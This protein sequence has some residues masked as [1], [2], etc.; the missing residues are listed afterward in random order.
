MKNL[1][2]ILP[3]FEIENQYPDKIVVGIDEAGRGPIAGPVVAGLV[4][5]SEN[6]KNDE[7]V[8]SVND[9]KKISKKKRK[10]LFEYLTKEVKF[11]VGVVNNDK[12]DEINILNATK[13]AMFR[14]YED[15][16]AKYAINVDVSLVDG[17]FD[18]F[19]SYET[20][21]NEVLPVIKGDEK[22]ILIACASIIAKEW[23]DDMMSKLSDEFSVYDWA[24]NSGYPTKFH[25]EKINECGITKYHRKSFAPVRKILEKESG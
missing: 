23:R 13:L 12:I 7:K 6:Q 20:N 21:I 3:N 10:D 22:S 19:K 25:I 18:P 9:S 14:A 24:K 4:Y 1:K 8:L 16:V 15:F 5:L 11:G 17:N 2:N